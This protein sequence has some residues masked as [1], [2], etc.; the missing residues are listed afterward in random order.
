M[1]VFG[2]NH[3]ADSTS[4]G[5]S[6]YLAPTFTKLVPDL[7]Q[8]KKVVGRW[9]RSLEAHYLENGS[10]KDLHPVNSVGRILLELYSQPMLF[11]DKIST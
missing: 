7:E 1:F 9:R 6:S 3:V 8:Y 10:A 4:S 11:L 5:A 2:A